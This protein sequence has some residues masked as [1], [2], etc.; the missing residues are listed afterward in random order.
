M[1]Q[2]IVAVVGRPNVGKSSLFN[3]ILGR[4]HAIVSDVAGTTRD[5]LI[6]DAHW[7]DYDFILIDTGGLESNPEGSIREKVQE[8][9]EMAMQAADV[10]V[11]MTDV[12]DGLT[13]ADHVAADRLRRASKPVILT[14]NKVD[15]D[16]RE[17]ASPEFHQ[18]GLGEPFLI[19]AY[20]NYGIYPLMDQVISHFP[21][22]EPPPDAMEAGFLEDAEPDPSPAEPTDLKLAIVG[23]TNVGKSML[24]NAILGQERSIVS[25]VAGTTRDALDTGFTYNNID[26]TLID[27]AG[28]RRPGQVQRGIEKYS[29]IRAVSAVNRS[30]IAF[31]VVDATELA[32]AQDAHIAGLAWDVCRGL[33]VVINKWDLIDQR[34]RGTRE[35]AVD[36]V[37]DRLHFMRYVPICFTSALEG[38]GIPGLMQLALELWR[39]RLRFVP[40]RELQ[41]VLADAMA[42]HAP[43]VGKGRRSKSRLNITRLRQGD[44]NPPTFLFTVEDP[45]LIH[46]SYQRYLENRLRDSFGFDH[47]HLRLVFKKS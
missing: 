39:E 20:H 30:D 44:V 41:Y 24:L 29:V 19:S 7:D 15:N 10:I 2:P 11:F 17:F 28:I 21:Y 22:Q 25:Q 12:I 33:I 8:Q 1:P 13:A 35:R 4:R 3:R 32:T 26:I 38:E 14:V 16:S 40:T 18:L 9:A 5:R 42:E 6:A 45:Q 34:V 37:R 27:T 23:R 47:T 43:P 31:L 46:F 36:M